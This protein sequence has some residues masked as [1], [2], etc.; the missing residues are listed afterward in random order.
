MA[1][2]SLLEIIFGVL[3]IGFFGISIVS[4]IEKKR[5]YAHFALYGA[6][7]SFAGSAIICFGF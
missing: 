7:I 3:T 5:D 4:L 1:I 2:L 6:I